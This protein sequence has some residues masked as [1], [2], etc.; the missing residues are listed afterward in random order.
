MTD[1]EIITNALYYYTECWFGRLFQA[2]QKAKDGTITPE[3][4]HAIMAL[5]DRV[6]TLHLAW[7]EKRKNELQ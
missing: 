2:A 3:E 6:S 7:Q 4:L 1:A 5:A